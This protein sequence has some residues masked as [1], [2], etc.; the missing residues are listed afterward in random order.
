MYLSRVSRNYCLGLPM[1]TRDALFLTEKIIHNSRCRVGFCNFTGDSIVRN[2][3]AFQ[4]LGEGMFVSLS[5]FR[6]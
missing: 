2:N 5:S 6:V 3:Y 4:S 1:L